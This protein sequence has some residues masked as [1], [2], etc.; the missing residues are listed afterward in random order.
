MSL[1]T[2]STLSSFLPSFDYL[3]FLIFCYYLVLLL[4]LCSNFE[5]LFV[6][7][8]PWY[9]RQEKDS[10][11]DFLCESRQMLSLCF[12]II[13]SILILKYDISSEG[14]WYIISIVHCQIWRLFLILFSNCALF[15]CLT[16]SGEKDNVMEGWVSNNNSV[17]GAKR[18][19]HDGV[20][21]ETRRAISERNVRSICCLVFGGHWFYTTSQ[22]SMRSHSLIIQ[23]SYG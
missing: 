7:A 12:A 16:G 23:Y 8:S 10:L 1:Y 3:L 4:L 21:G 9:L 22:R 6:N 20:W 2:P 14:I 15:R 11:T 17:S 5:A 19:L 13:H 18:R